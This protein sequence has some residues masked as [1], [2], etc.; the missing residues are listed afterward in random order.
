[1]CSCERDCLDN[2]N[3]DYKYAFSFDDFLC[4]TEHKV[5]TIRCKICRYNV[6]GFARNYFASAV[7]SCYQTDKNL[8]CT[9]CKQLLHALNFSMKDLPKEFDLMEIFGNVPESGPIFFIRKKIIILWYPLTR[10][11]GEFFFENKEMM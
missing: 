5:F 9:L 7:C 4:N 3:V 1:M 6:S 2:L 8:I 11:I 10:L